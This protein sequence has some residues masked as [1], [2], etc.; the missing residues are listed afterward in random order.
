MPI[1]RR[2]F[3]LL[4]GLALLLTAATADAARVSSLQALHRDGQTFLT[5]VFNNSAGWKFDVYASDTPIYTEFQLQGAR[6]LG[7]V[8]DSTY[9]DRRLSQVLAGHYYFRI[10]PD[11]MALTPSMGMFVATPRMT[12]Q[13]YFAV[14]ARSGVLPA[15]RTLIAGSNTLAD[16]I[17]EF[18]GPPKPVFQRTIQTGGYTVDVYTLWTSNE[19]TADF[20]AMA[21][22]PSMPFD[23]GI[24]RGTGGS[25]ML[26]RPHARSGH[27]LQAVAGSGIEGEWRLALDDPLWTPDINSFFFGYHENYDITGS[28]NLPPL[29][30]TVRDYT[31]RRVIH[32]VSWARDEFPIDRGRMYAEG[33]SMGGIGSTFLAFHRPDLIAAVMTRVAKF[34]FSFLQEPTPNMPFN[35]AGTLRQVVD[36]LWGPTEV[37]LPAPGGES[38]YDHM[39]AG[40]LARWREAQGVPPL[41]AFNGR[42]DVIVGWAE[43][44]GFYES[45]NQFRQ[46]GYF[47]WDNRDHAGNTTAAWSPMHDMRYLYRFR[48]DRS[49][50]A[51]SNC[52]IDM[53][54]GGGEPAEGDSVGTI[55]GFVEWDTTVVDNPSE[56]SVTLR[57]RDLTTRWG[58]LP[59]PQQCTVDLTPRRLQRLQVVD[60]FEYRWQVRRVRDGRVIQKGWTEPDGQHLLTL[61]DVRVEREGVIVR[62]MFEGKAVQSEIDGDLGLPPAPPPPPE[63]VSEGDNAYAVTWPEDGR[64][65]VDLIDLAGRH[66]RQIDGGFM[67][68]GRTRYA[69]GLEGLP[70]GVYFLAARQGE[71]AI[72]TR[73]IALVR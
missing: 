18:T 2:M 50:P 73:R 6:Y 15:E 72:T 42:Q 57:M 32:T 27:F 39:N 7:C 47:F 61:K 46:G 66:V 60:G 9:Y 54:P 4:S 36:R 59:A 67:R 65:R 3:A 58:V 29:T 53:T 49:W 70:S 28:A 34:D 30:G 25:A 48:S 55:N 56:W 63:I 38:V 52:S 5:W 22:R 11:G 43:K 68:A 19:D 21:N 14:L 23:C 16:P 13:R 17:Q 69:V 8:G 44:I 12:G 1:A 41:L 35:P 24:V 40:V 10:E 51:L 71:T 64:G 45:M 20:P 62:I 31:L 26:V 37:A 33:I